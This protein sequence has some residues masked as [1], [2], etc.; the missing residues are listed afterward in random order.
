MGGPLLSAKGRPPL[1]ALIANKASILSHSE[2]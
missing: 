1:I 2:L